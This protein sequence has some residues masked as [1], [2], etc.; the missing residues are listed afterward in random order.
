M[1]ITLV[2][3]IILTLGLSFLFVSCT[4]IET[5]NETTYAGINSPSPEPTRSPSQIPGETLTQPANKSISSTG[6][7]GMMVKM[8]LRDLTLKSEMI[9][10]GTVR[11]VSYQKDGNSNIFTLVTL[12]VEQ[13]V[14]G[15]SLVE[16]PIRVAGGTLDG[17]SVTVEDAPAFTQGEKV[18]VFLR[19]Q[20]NITYSVVGGFQGKFTIVNDLVGNVPLSQFIKQIQG[21]ISP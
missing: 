16:V 6:I 7:S 10:T 12:T 17:K 5:N 20:D 2:F 18:I 14:K 13:V 3:S 4:S 11:S 8:D 19:K 1:R 21:Y 15:D 9:A